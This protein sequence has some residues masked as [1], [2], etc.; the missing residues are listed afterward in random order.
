VN[1][2]RVLRIRELLI[3]FGNL[4]KREQMR[5][6]ADMNDYMYASPQRRKQMLRE[7]QGHHHMLARATEEMDR[8]ATSTGNGSSDVVNEP[9]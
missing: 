1:E 2:D 7:W 5:F 9:N 3:G 6:L 8:I 4:H